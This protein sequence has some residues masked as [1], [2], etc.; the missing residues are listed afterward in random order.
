M[1]NKDVNKQKERTQIAGTS[2]QDETPESP[3]KVNDLEA[4]ED[5]KGGGIGRGISTPVGTSR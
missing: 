1:G 3:V 4:K 2:N 5:V